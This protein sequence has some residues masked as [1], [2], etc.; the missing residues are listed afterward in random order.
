VLK[1]DTA[2]ALA[3][4]GFGNAA[5]EALLRFFG[6]SYSGLFAIWVALQ[7]HPLFT[8]IGAGSPDMATGESK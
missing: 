8:R 6:D 4:D 5:T 7:R 2:Y 3:L 1:R